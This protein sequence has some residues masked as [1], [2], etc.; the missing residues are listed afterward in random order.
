MGL[1]G[2]RV[3]HLHGIRLLALAVLAVGVQ[4]IPEVTLGTAVP[5]WSKVVGPARSSTTAWLGFDRQVIRV[6]AR[7]RPRFRLQAVG[8]VPIQLPPAPNVDLTEP[9]GGRAPVNG[10]VRLTFSEPMDRTSIQQS[11]TVEPALQG[12]LE[13][14]DPQTLVFRPAVQLAYQT[15][16]RVSVAGFG[17]AQ[18][19]IAAAASFTFTTVLP[20]PNVP[21]PFTLTF[22]DCGT[23]AQIEAILTALADR[24]LKAIF[25]PTGRCRDMFPWLIPTLIGAGHRVCNHTYSHPDLSRLSAGAIASEIQRGVSV[26]CDLFRPPYGAMDRR[27]V[28]YSVATSLGYKVQLWD[29]DTRDW[30][31]TPTD[32]MVSMIRARGGVVLMHMHGLHTVEA[33]RAL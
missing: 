15:S 33:I 32:V 6:S 8:R 14:P 7:A 1:F 13:W 3:G 31:G 18:Q 11:F 25:F 5:A 4:V 12:D 10:V 21:F 19:R 30:A 22:D 17:L 23:A 28:V 24:G 26:Q 20:P 29:V 27:G 9:V 2:L 16:Y